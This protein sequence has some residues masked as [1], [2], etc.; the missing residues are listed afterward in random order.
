MKNN[1][2]KILALAGIVLGLGACDGKNKN[3]SS[4]PSSTDSSTESS[5]T[6]SST[7]SET[8]IVDVA[9]SELF[10]LD[11]EASWALLGQKVRVEELAVQGLYGNTVIGGG[12]TGQ[13]ITDLIG[14][15]IQV[16]EMPTFVKGSGWGANITAV[17]TVADVEGRL[18]LEDAEVEVVSEREYS[19]SSYTGGLPIY[20]CPE[21]LLKRSF[22]EQ[23]ILRQMSGGYFPGNFQVAS[24]PEALEDETSSTYFEVVFPGEDTDASDENNES[25]IA[26][27]VPEGLSE[28]ARTRFNNYFFTE[29]SEVQVGDFVHVD[30]VLQYDR[31]ANIGMG[32]V[33][34][35]FGVIEDADAADIPTIVNDY[36]D[37]VSHFQDSFKAPFVDLDIDIPFSYILDD[38]YL[39]TDF[40]T[41][42]NDAYKDAFCRVEKDYVTAKFTANFK[43][44]RV[45]DYLDAIYEKLVGTEENPGE[46]EYINAY[47]QYGIMI[48]TK[49]NAKGQVDAEVFAQYV[50]DSCLDIF[51]IA[52]VFSMDDEY[53][54]IAEAEAAYNERVGAILEDSSWATALP[55]VASSD[56][57]N[58]IFDYTN[59]LYYFEKYSATVYEYKFTIEFASSASDEDKAEFA[60]GCLA[61]LQAGGFTRAYYAGFGVEGLFNATTNE[62]VLGTGLNN[63]GAFVINVAVLAGNQINGVSYPFESDAEL[64]A[65]INDEWAYWNGASAQYFPTSAS[66]FTSFT[67]GD[68]AVVEWSFLDQEYNDWDSGW[69]YTPSVI[70]TLTYGSDLSEQNIEALVSMLTGLGFVA[71]THAA[72]GEGY[73]NQT[74]YEFVSFMY[75]GADLMILAGLVAVPAVGMAITIADAGE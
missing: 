4:S 54:T 5:S 18:V 72:F 70:F 40:K 26:V 53:A 37:V 20:Y 65:A 35:N 66:S 8:P 1:L 22:W 7:S 63:N 49:E 42:W 33:Y 15:E 62:F 6:E 47:E 31:S 27:Q 39:T 2:V 10:E 25:L 16:E 41:L 17:G 36:A 75:D 71:A 14:V 73:F 19:G 12:A 24:L 67:L 68:N 46:Y 44:A 43:P 21:N 50:N 60:E 52:Q 56:I 57:E 29:G 59:E 61:F 58:V 74:T 69:V 3:S 9:L 34:T 45:D 48:F 28:T 64:I 32:Y 51:Y 13:Y 11:D 38:T 23:E 55:A 30:T